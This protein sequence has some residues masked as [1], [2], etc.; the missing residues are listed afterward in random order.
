MDNKLSLEERLE[1]VLRVD[2]QMQGEQ[3]NLLE[4]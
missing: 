2:C 1:A 4:F 3:K